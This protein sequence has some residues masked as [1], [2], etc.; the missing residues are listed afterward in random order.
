MGPPSGL[1]EK[2]RAWRG[3]HVNWWPLRRAVPCPPPCSETP[4]KWKKVSKCKFPENSVS[5][6]Q[7]LQTVY[8][9]LSLG[10]LSLSLSNPYFLRTGRDMNINRGSLSIFHPATNKPS[11]KF[12]GKTSLFLKSLASEI[13]KALLFRH[14]KDIILKFR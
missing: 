2:S 4:L 3:G 1:V 9:P 10:S 7:H 13:Q 11:V 6:E 14:Q 5:V 12:Q 8:L